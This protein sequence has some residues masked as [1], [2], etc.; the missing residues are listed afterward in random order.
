MLSSPGRLCSHGAQFALACVQQK[1]EMPWKIHAK[2]NS[3]RSCFDEVPS[4]KCPILMLGAIV[5][6]QKWEFYC[7]WQLLVLPNSGGRTLATCMG[8]VS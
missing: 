3:F 7:H 4:E 1:I 6:S 8:G 2:Y 5:P